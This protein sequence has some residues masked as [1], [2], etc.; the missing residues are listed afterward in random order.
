MAYLGTNTTLPS[1]EIYVSEVKRT[2][3]YDNIRGSANTTQDGILWVEQ[4]WD[5]TAE[6]DPSN[7]IWDYSQAI[8]VSAASSATSTPNSSSDSVGSVFDI[9]VYAPFWRVRFKAS[10]S[11]S[12][13][14]RI[15]ARLT[16]E[17]DF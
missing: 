9:I 7:A 13:D 5:A 3:W 1:D 15:H 17:G 6:L 16:T 10:A 4:S 14:I 12:A 8:E 2:D 11:A